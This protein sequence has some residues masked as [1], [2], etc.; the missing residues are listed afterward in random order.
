MN[1]WKMDKY[2]YLVASDDPSPGPSGERVPELLCDFAD[3]E[4]VK[5]ERDAMGLV[6]SVIGRNCEGFTGAHRCYDPD[7]SKPENEY[8]WPCVAMGH[9][10]KFRG[11][12]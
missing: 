6:L 8:C 4:R 3:Y 2:G 1:L 11:D 7:V 5:G 9:L 12:P 10:R